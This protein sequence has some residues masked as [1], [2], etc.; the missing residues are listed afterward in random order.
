MSVDKAKDDTE[1]MQTIGLRLE[2]TVDGH[3]QTVVTK[4]Y[5]VTDLP[6]DAWQ[7]LTVTRD[8]S[9]DTLRVLV[10]VTPSP[11]TGIRG[12]ALRFDDALF[13]LTHNSRPR[14]DCR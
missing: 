10:I 13:E 7:K 2:S 3:Q 9:N 6:P 8:S 1:D 4:T 5:R 11:I 14:L 12:G